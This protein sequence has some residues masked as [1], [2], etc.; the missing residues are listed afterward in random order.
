MV[1]KLFLTPPDTP[2]ETQGRCITV[3]ASREWLQSLNEALLLLTGYWNWEQVNDTDLTPSQAAD[4]WSTIYD[5]YF[6]S[7][8]SGTPFCE[9]PADPDLGVDILIK[10]IRRSTTGHTEELVGGEW[11]EPTGDYEVPPIAAR[12][13]ATATERK[14]LAA[15][16]AAEVMAQIYE[17]A[18]DAYSI[19]ATQAAV[20]TAIYDFIIIAVGAFAGP[21]AAAYA[22]YG[23]TFFDVF[24][25]VV[26]T[27][28]AD[29][30]T[31]GFTDEVRCLL[32]EHATDTS[33][34][35]T[36][37]WAAI[38][39]DIS[40]KFLRAGAALDT[41]KA[42]LWG[43][44]GYLLDILAAGGLDTAGTQT[45]VDDAD[46]DDCGTWCYTMDFEVDDFNWVHW[47]TVTSGSEGT[48]FIG[49]GW[50]CEDGYQS[51]ANEYFRSVRLKLTGLSEFTLT[52]I[53][54]EINLTEG[55][56]VS[57]GEYGLLVQPRD[58]GTVYNLINYPNS[59]LANGNAQIF[60]WNGVQGNLDAIWMYLGC[61]TRIGAAPTSGS[62]YIKKLILEG[63]GANP[64]GSDNC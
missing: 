27:L 55:A 47:N 22:S 62:G 3:P 40:D 7:D 53:R 43:Q 59:A 46:C 23:K 25:D 21:T 8:C 6:G 34:V 41:N 19:S 52:S 28:S 9:V 51:A 64:F 42:L 4:A 5:A 11:V 12:S 14:C 29:V 36:F 18:T 32:Y 37:D 30:W 15:A 54:V 13:E 10:I 38:R 50:K 35:V 60:N 58:G 26:T 33:A 24:Y 39:G 45:I 57:G 44:V 49:D 31:S 63:T 17:E 48:W 1:R 16:N 56:F 2:E 61:A 20:F